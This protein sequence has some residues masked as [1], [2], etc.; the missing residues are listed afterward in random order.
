MNSKWIVLRL[1]FGDSR[2]EDVDDPTDLIHQLRGGSMAVPKACQIEKTTLSLNP[3]SLPT[4]SSRFSHIPAR[5]PVMLL[6]F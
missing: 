3:M 1:G 4:S 5:R 6:R 2:N